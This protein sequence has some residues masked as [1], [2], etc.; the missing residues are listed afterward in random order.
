MDKVN[1]YIKTDFKGVRAS[2][3]HYGF[4]LE[5]D[6]AAGPYTREEFGIIPKATVN[7]A[8]AK[9]LLMALKKLKKTC[10]LTIY[11]DSEYVVA[12]T[13]WYEGWKRNGWLTANG[14]NVANRDVWEELMPVLAMH[15]Y[16]FEVRQHHKYASWLRSELERAGKRDKH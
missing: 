7:R 1:I 13:R 6:T 10:E 8:E 16:R 4:V 14:G 12:G 11:T 5:T 9:A 3:G 2:D 15:T